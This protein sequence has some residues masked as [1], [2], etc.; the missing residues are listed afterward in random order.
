MRSFR[1]LFI[2]SILIK[3]ALFA[4]LNQTDS[5]G[6]KQGLWQKKYPK[7]DLLLYEGQFRDDKPYGTFTYY[8]PDGELK[9]TIEHQ[10]DGHHS[11][12]RFYFENKMLMSE[13]FFIDQKKDSIWINYNKEGLLISLESFKNDKLNGKKIIYYLE[14]QIETEKLNPLSIANYKNDT[15]NGEF[16]EFFSTGKLKYIGKYHNGKQVGEWKEFYPNGNLFKLSRYKDDRLHG[17]STTYTK[18]G[19]ENG[20]FMYQFGE[21]LTAKDLEKFL[22]LCEKKGIDPNE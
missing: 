13:G 7:S 18:D 17:W 12:A 8:Y 5:K 9:A 22:K 21:K 1:L 16:K 20:K 11:K 19:E 15:L 10:S 14:G 3:S 6:R 2:F 4:Q